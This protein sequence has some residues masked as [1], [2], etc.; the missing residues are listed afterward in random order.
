[1]ELKMCSATFGNIYLGSG[2]SVRSSY[3]DRDNYTNG[4]EYDAQWV[5]N[6]VFDFRVAW[7]QNGI[8]RILTLIFHQASD[9]SGNCQQKIH[10]TEAGMYRNHNAATLVGAIL[11]AQQHQETEESNN[12]LQNEHSHSDK[13]QP[14]M[15]TVEIHFRRLRQIV[16]IED[17][18][19]SQSHTRYGA[20]VKEHM[21]QLNID[22]LQA[23]AKAVQ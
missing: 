15:H 14:R 10:Q 2:W 7:A 1:M 11:T 3:S 9:A 21:D 5:Y 6:V 12:E 13:A 17:G 23:A 4:D 18:Q 16:R 8:S 20:G 22:V 19:K